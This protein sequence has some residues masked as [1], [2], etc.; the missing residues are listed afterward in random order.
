MPRPDLNVLLQ[1]DPKIGQS[2]V[3]GD[4][5][6]D[7]LKHLEQAYKIYLE[8]SLA[9]QNWVVVNCMKDDKML[10]KISIHKLITALIKRS[11]NDY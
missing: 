2:N 7:S 5:H 8:Q 11:L 10:S 9:E 1:V 3:A 4:L 6:E